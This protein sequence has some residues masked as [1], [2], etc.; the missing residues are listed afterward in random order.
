MLNRII[1]KNKYILII[2]FL[3]LAPVVYFF[4]HK[5]F[6]NDPRM[7]P[8]IKE[9]EIFKTSF[10]SYGVLN[11]VDVKNYNCFSGNTFIKSQKIQDI[12]AGQDVDNVSCKFEINI[13]TN[14]LEKWSV[15]LQIKDKVFCVDSLGNNFETPGITVTATCKGE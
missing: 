2:L 7:K 10:G 4:A 1:K 11:G 14:I 13:L 8:R 12:L 15:S 5:Y 3:A 6:S 9:A